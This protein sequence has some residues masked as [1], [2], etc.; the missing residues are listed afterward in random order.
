MVILQDL[1]LGHFSLGP[2]F[3]KSVAQLS[4]EIQMFKFLTWHNGWQDKSSEEAD[5]HIE[6]VVD[7]EK[8]EL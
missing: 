6:E 5:A 2:A 8:D 7:E 3:W 1:R 4:V